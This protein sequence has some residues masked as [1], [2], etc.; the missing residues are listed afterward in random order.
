L[1]AAVSIRVLLADD[2]PLVRAGVRMILSTEADVEVVGEADDGATAIQAVRHLRPDVVL[3]DLRMPGTD[4]IAATRAITSAT[5]TRVVV[6][7][8]FDTDG[9]VESALRAGASGFLTKDVP[10]EELVAAIRHIAAGDAVVS[11]AA[12][13]R[14]LQKTGLGTGVPGSSGDAS[15]AAAAAAR[16]EGASGRRDSADARRQAAQQVARLTQREREVLALVAAGLTNAEVAE[17]LVVAES[18]AKTHVSRMMQK[19]GARDRVQAVIIA[20]D[21][22]LVA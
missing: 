17:A 19:L 21:A 5:S 3:M 6:L 10:P 1:D 2:Q 12:L 14:L 20:Y 13:R 18:T 16:A 7:T 22:G 11:P 4:G 9:N 15:P 8:T